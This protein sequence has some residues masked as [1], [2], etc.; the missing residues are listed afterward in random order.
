MRR[1][2]ADRRTDTHTALRRATQYLL[3]SLS[4]EGNN[5]YAWTKQ[6]L[7]Q[8]AAPFKSLHWQPTLK[9][10]YSWH[11]RQLCSVCVSWYFRCVSV[12]LLCSANFAWRLKY[13][14]C[15]VL[16]C[17]PSFSL[18]FVSLY[19]SFPRPPFPS[20]YI[21]LRFPLLLLSLSPS[22]FSPFFVSLPFPS[23][24]FPESGS[25]SL[26]GGPGLLPT[27]IWNLLCDLVTNL[28][29]ASLHF[30]KH[31]CQRWGGHGKLPPKYATG[32][33]GLLHSF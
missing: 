30:L 4:V 8:A 16:Y 23:F 28:W 7:G 25:R 22:S 11:W 26:D 18:F 12:S 2:V 19:L 29:L 9:I 33:T 6:D 13:F 10:D 1:A 5:W 32:Y 27:K 31:F 14:Y 17:A 15:I 24:F 21:P 20:L 3:R